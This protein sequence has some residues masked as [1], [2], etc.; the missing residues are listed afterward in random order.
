MRLTAGS[1]RELHWHLADEWAYMLS[2]RARVTLLTPD[3]SMF[4]DDVAEGD[5]WLFPAGYP[6]SIQG[7]EPGGCEFL[8]VFNQG[9]FSE[10]STL[11]LSDWLAHT[12]PGILA[13]N[14]GL[15][16]AA[17]AKLPTGPLYIFPDSAPG[18]PL[19]EQQ[20]AAGMTVPP[21][22]D[23][24]FTFRM[25]SMPPAL[26][27]AHGEVRIVD[28]R[29]FP[30]SKHFAAGLLITEPGAGR[31]RAFGPVGRRNSRHSGGQE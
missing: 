30:A 20:V 1:F 9:D 8:L 22:P 2:G 3:G 13:K 31:R 15:D 14:F 26:T 16:Q 10:E 12:P 29:N 23:K 19:A 27:S 7:L 4:V 6:H 11:L 18:M 24:A 5:L 25:R 28:S 17:L 21:T